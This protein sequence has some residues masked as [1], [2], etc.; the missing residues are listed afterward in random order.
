MQQLD[1]SSMCGRF[2]SSLPPDEMRRVFETLGETPN[3][4]PSWN[5]AP[6]QSALVVRRHPETGER[7]LD[8]L[9]WGL[10]PSFIKDL[11]A[12][13]KPI[14]A[15]SE[16]AATTDLFRS[17]MT[18]RRCL[19]PV[20]AF[21]EWRHQ[22]DGKQ[23]FAFARR[24]GEQ[25]ALAGIWEGWRG[26]ENEILRTFAILTTAANATMAPVHNRMPV[27]LEPADWRR[28]LGEVAGD[29]GSL[30]RPAAD[31]LLRSWP[32][33]RRVNGPRHDGADLLEPSTATG[34]VTR[35]GSAL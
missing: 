12:A 10:V 32:V 2:A 8:V 6:S 3:H 4:P 24:D 20:N 21:Y 14:N 11:K 29:A 23:P 31:D 17:A 25:L 16:T 1:F 9:R 26:P 15:R 22:A 30:L 27:I 5:V 34:P 33:S 28:W 13:R 18:S 19:V 35:P 7:R